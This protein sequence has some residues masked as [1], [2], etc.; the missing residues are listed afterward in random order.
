MGSPA[1]R[2][3]TERNDRLIWYSSSVGTHPGMVEVIIQRVRRR[4]GGI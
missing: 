1:W 3:P 4:P 2:N